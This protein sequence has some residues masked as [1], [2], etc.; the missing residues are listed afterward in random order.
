[1]AKL[2][3]TKSKIAHLLATYQKRLS[4]QA[5]ETEDDILFYMANKHKF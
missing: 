3:E 1:M 5:L 2:D 4:R